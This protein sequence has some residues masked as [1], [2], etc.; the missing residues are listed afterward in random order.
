MSQII[1]PQRRV[2]RQQPQQAVVLKPEYAAGVFMIPGVNSGTLA[3]SHSLRVG[4][5]GREIVAPHT[6]AVATSGSLGY[7]NLETEWT[8][9]FLTRKTQQTNWARLIIAGS[10]VNGHRVELLLHSSGRPYIN[11]VGS[12][13]SINTY[14]EVEPVNPSEYQCRVMSR[15]GGV[16][17]YW[18]NGVNYTITD[19]NIG[20]VTPYLPLVVGAHDVENNGGGCVALMSVLRVGVDDDAGLRISENPWQI[21]AKRDRY[22]FVSLGGGGTSSVYSDSALSYYIRSL[23]SSDSGISYA[24]RNAIYQDDAVG[25]YLRASVAQN[26]AIGYALR[27][28]I[29]KD[30][31]AAYL[32]RGLV[33]TDD[34]ETYSLR[35]L[36]QTSDNETYTVRSAVSADTAAVYDVL[37]S[38]SVASNSTVSYSVRGSVTANSSPA[39]VVRSATQSDQVIGYSLRSSVSRDLASAYGVAASESSVY[40]DLSASYSVDGVTPACPTAES[41]AA[42]VVSA[43]KG[44]TIPANIKQVNDVTVQGAG[45]K[46]NPWQPV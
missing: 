17:R 23:L 32:M 7:V 18:L 37:S 29:A 41:I 34:N 22:A 45:T 4:A 2:W 19:A 42:A 44:T 25:Y 33:Q 11:I 24:I 27:S 8:L 16:T 20:T 6:A 30:A 31:T 5:K 39:Y 28:A 38:S 35:G 14:N 26:S 43:L 1:V 9:I 13:G 3:S 15:K 46:L 10:A 36:V 21:F 40:S 12:L